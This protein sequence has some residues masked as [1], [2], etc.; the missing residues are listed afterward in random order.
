ME[1]G[2]FHKHIFEKFVENTQCKYKNIIRYNKAIR[3][4]GIYRMPKFIQHK[5]LREME[6]MCLIKLQDKRNIVLITQEDKNEI[7][8][9]METKSFTEIAKIYGVSVRAVSRWNQNLKNVEEKKN[10]F[11]PFP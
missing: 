1:I 6:D 10:S 3:I 11:N 8:Q 5:F 9:L 4:L 7:A 2:I